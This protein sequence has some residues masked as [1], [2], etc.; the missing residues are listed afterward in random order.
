MLDDKA[1]HVCMCSHVISRSAAAIRSCYW[2]W[3]FS[4]Y[5]YPPYSSQWPRMRIDS[6]QRYYSAK[7]LDKWPSVDDVISS[8]EAFSKAISRV[9]WMRRPQYRNSK[10][11]VPQMF[12]INKF[13]SNST[14]Q[15]NDVPITNINRDPVSIYIYYPCI[16][17]F[18][19]YVQG[20]G[21]VPS[22]TPARITF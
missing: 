1:P 3:S 7:I 19:K 16:R 12:V 5:L 6:P 17:D 20:E 14:S 2:A 18:I 9:D 15:L 11:Y 22:P 10:L 4:I 13:Y 8:V 21:T